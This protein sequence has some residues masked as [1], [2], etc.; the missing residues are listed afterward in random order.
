MNTFI[1]LL[2]AGHM[3]RVVSPLYGFELTMLRMKYFPPREKDEPD[4]PIYDKF[5]IAQFLPS[6]IFQP[7]R[8]LQL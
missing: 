8:S 3:V 7:F 2:I 5:A 1:I 6:L 4:Q